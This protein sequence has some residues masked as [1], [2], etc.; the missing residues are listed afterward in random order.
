MSTRLV[1][2]VLINTIIIS[3]GAARIPGDGA[4]Q[5]ERRMKPACM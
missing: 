5:I 1:K 3:G 4:T 2:H